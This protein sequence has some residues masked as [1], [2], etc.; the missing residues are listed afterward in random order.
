MYF[1]PLSPTKW[2]EHPHTQVRWGG[3]GGSSTTTGVPDWLRPQVEKAAND[4]TALYDEGALSNV[5]GLTPEQMDAYN[6]KL[7]LG[8]Q[9]GM[10]DQLGGDS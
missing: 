5:A 1:N 2:T 10:L 7:E 6:R 8:K 3:G 4:A 9:G